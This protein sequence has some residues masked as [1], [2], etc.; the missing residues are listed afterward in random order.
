MVIKYNIFVCCCFFFRSAIIFFS[1]LS[2][3]KILSGIPSECQ[4]EKNF[5]L[6]LAAVY[7]QKTPADK[8]FIEQREQKVPV[9]TAL[10][11]LELF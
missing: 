2:S 7:Q 10:S 4:P 6:D 11:V 3:P 8:E 9:R 1:K 5:V